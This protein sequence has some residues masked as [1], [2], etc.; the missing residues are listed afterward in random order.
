MVIIEKYLRP[1]RSNFLLRKVWGSEVFCRHCIWCGGK[2]SGLLKSSHIE[3]CSF[4]SILVPGE[5][6]WS[7]HFIY[8]ITLSKH[9]EYCF[10]PLTLHYFQL[11]SLHLHPSGLYHSYTSSLSHHLH[12]LPENYWFL[13][14]MF[15]QPFPHTFYQPPTGLYIPLFLLPT[16]QT[17][18]SVVT[19]EKTFCF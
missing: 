2:A 15:T 18:C 17:Y 16:L 10:H 9:S 4:G 3:Y 5:F 7:K 12:L 8:S 13:S 19:A 11:I 14:K 6:V 1:F